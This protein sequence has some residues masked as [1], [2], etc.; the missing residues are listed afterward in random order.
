MADMEDVLRKAVGALSDMRD[1]MNTM[2]SDHGQTKAVLCDLV[3]GAVKKDEDMQ[4]MRAV[5]LED[6]R[7]IMAGSLKTGEDM[8][9]MQNDMF[10]QMCALFG[11]TH[12]EMRKMRRELDQL[13]AEVAEMKRKQRFQELVTQEAKLVFSDAGE[14][15]RRA[16]REAEVE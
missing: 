13:R 11:K 16:A 3:S 10:G 12:T 5:Q 1:A 15:R 2:Q 4:K 7:T 8:R 9:T 6:M 14:V